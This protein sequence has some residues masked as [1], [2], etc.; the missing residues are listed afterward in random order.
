MIYP[1]EE[2]SEHG[3][4]WHTTFIGQLMQHN[5]WLYN[6][7]DQVMLNNPQIKSIVEIGTGRGALTTIFGLWGIKLNIPVLSIDIAKLYDENILNKLNVTLLQQD[8]FSESTKEYILSFI[9]DKPT[10]IYCDGALKMK[11]F[12]TYAPLIPSSSIISAH[13]LGTWEFS[14]TEALKII[15]PNIVDPYMP[16]LWNDLNVRLAIFKKK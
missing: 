16:E 12:T 13:D 8:E 11:E 4:P 14:D 15:G 5:Y 10:W 9:Q 6:I 1:Y 7:V 3:L 2:K